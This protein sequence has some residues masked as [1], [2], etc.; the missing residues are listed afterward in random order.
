[1]AIDYSK[2]SQG[3]LDKVQLQIQREVAGKR[4]SILYGE[5]GDVIALRKRIIEEDPALRES[6]IRGEKF[7]G[8]ADTKGVRVPLS[9]APVSVKAG[10]RGISGAELQEIEGR[11]A[12]LF[13]SG[14]TRGTGLV[15]TRE[16]VKTESQV[17]VERRE[18]FFSDVGL[19]QPFLTE[20]RQPTK[21]G[22]PQSTK[23]FRVDPTKDLFLGGIKPATVEEAKQLRIEEQSRTGT[24]FAIGPERP[25]S[26]AERIRRFDFR[27]SDVIATSTKG[28]VS[29]PGTVS[30]SVLFGGAVV[31]SQL[32]LDKLFP[33]QPQIETGGI[34]RIG[35]DIVTF[36]AFSPAFSSTFVIEKS[37][38]PV[39]VEFFG[40][41][42]LQEGSKLR[43]DLVFR[44]GEGQR[45]VATSLTQKVK[46]LDD[47][48]LSR[49]FTQGKAYT[50][51]IKFPTLKTVTKF[52]DD[53][54]FA[55][56]SSLTK[57]G[58]IKI[59][60]GDTGVFQV[61]PIT[62]QAS[63]GFVGTAQKGIVFPT[64]KAITTARLETFGA[65]SFSTGDD[66]IKIFGKSQTGTGGQ[67]IFTG[68]IKKLPAL[69]DDATKVIFSPTPSKGGTASLG[70]I[71]SPQALQSSQQSVS[72]FYA[73]QTGKVT[74]SIVPATVSVLPRLTTLATTTPTQKT[75][76]LP[77]T[78]TIQ[79]QAVVTK[80]KV[81]PVQ[82][83]SLNTIQTPQL[84]LLQATVPAT[85][86]RTISLT[87][88]TSVTP[89]KQRV[90]VST[91]QVAKSLSKP[92]LTTGFGAFPTVPITPPHK[93]PPIIPF[94][95]RGKGRKPS[96]GLFTVS[97]RRFGKFKPIAKGVSLTTATSLGKERV[98]G[99]LA[100]TFK[101]TPQSKGVSFKGLG[102]PAGFRIGKGGVFIEKRKHRLSRKGE[103]K[104]IQRAK[105]R[106]KR[107]GG[108]K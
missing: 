103:K 58:T 82:I 34:Q 5:R 36:G 55:A 59:P 92:K 78:I 94:F 18:G 54:F 79:Q 80:Q 45:G 10:Q 26:Q 106:K 65:R 98:A 23:T 42:Q 81:T 71:V 87:K 67:S 13:G 21:P 64:G 24:Q 84:K 102:T 20:F 96:K 12:S 29:T 85:K 77:K 25:E 38:Q 86:Q 95:G 75:I 33:S 22:D 60:I 40:A 57:G 74:P 7:F 14:I 9:T 50:Q 3:E 108:K 6:L 1:M 15:S 41:Q 63:V 99:T 2:F 8:P 93:L 100:A 43:T 53:T 28:G 90:V 89:T 37:L 73:T 4:G 72:A 68:T 32:R 61:L 69:S 27:L 62:K 66:L 107:K 39:K 46:Q 97:V 19:S 44:T 35:S 70:K 47:V 17:A 30:K 52:S 16:G 88:L 101:L 31:S 51:G 48:V 11:R 91:A 76:I 105:K 104:E 56:Q 83:A 49:T